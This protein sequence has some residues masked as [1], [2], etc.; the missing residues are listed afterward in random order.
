VN[1]SSAAAHPSTPRQGRARDI[2]REH[3][4]EIAES[5]EG[6]IFHVPSGT[7]GTRYYV[8]SLSRWVCE[9]ADFEHRGESC[10]HLIAAEMVRSSSASC[11]GCS[12][13]FLR[14]DL[15]EVTE[16]HESITWFVGDRLCRMCA[17]SH[18]VL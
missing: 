11:A 12:G 14:A 13:R 10:K 16:D 9:C 3:A 4:R 6:A 17:L 8:V 18:G 2:Y 1:K 5:A 15:H 7:G